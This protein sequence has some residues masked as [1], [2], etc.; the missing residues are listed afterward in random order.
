[1]PNQRTTRYVHELCARIVP[2]SASLP[3]IYYTKGVLE[4]RRKFVELASLIFGIA[5]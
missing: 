1:M 2:D 4:L 5:F 3:G